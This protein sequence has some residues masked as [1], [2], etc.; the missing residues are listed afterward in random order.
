MQ[1]VLSPQTLKESTLSFRVGEE[2]DR[3]MLV[4]FLGRAGYTSVKVIEEREDR[5]D[6]ER[7]LKREDKAGRFGTFG[8]ILKN[9]KLK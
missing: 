6:Y 5:E 7:F 1:R 8:D 2:I 9:L 3:E 4:H